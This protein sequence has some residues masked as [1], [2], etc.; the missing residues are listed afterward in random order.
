MRKTDG[1]RPTGKAVL[2]AA[3]VDRARTHLPLRCSIRDGWT[4]L[5]VANL[6]ANMTLSLTHRD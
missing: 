3:T 5:Q 1:Y 6:F 2:G 4:S